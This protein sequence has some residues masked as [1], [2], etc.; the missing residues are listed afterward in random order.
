M[1][2]TNVIEMLHDAVKTHGSQAKVGKM[3][4]YSTATISQ[5][6]SGN[7]KGGLETFLARV[8]EVFG[9]RI[10]PCPLLGDIPLNRCVRERRRQFS[11][12]NP[13]RVQ[14]YRECRRCQFNSDRI[15]IGREQ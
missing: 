1:T 9:T 4:D 8:E 11:T 12:S 3:L 15:E 6:L 7:Y 2:E 5:V 13:L 10:I 14:L